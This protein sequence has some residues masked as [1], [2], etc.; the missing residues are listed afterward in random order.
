MSDKVVMVGKDFKTLIGAMTRFTGVGSF[1][2][3]D[4]VN[5]RVSDGQATA[6]M[7]GIVLSRATAFASGYCGLMALDGRLVESFANICSD[8]A[9]IIFYSDENSLVIRAGHREVIGASVVGHDHPVPD[10]TTMLVKLDVTKDIGRKI[11]YLSEVAY[12]D[13]SRPEVNC[14]ML[15]GNGRAMAANQKV[16]ASVEVSYSQ[17]V[18]IPLVLA[19][20]L[21]TGE[22]VYA[23]EKETVVTS[24]AAVYC[25]PAP[26][27]AQNGFPVALIERHDSAN[28]RVVAS[29]M[30]SGLGRIIQECESCLGRIAKTDAIARILIKEDRIEFSSEV[31]NA[32]FRGNIK[33]AG[34]AVGTVLAAPLAELMHIVPMIDGCSVTLSVGGNGEMFIAFPG[35]WVMMASYTES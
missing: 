24:G 13:N 6:S 14:V 12:G 22:S 5:I 28:R 8:V 32:K 25:M 7:F 35:G 1:G 29:C 31:G 4:L 18:A 27:Q 33:A 19:K 34:S 11:R 10:L 3:S 2:G 23:G 26:I 16:I 20:S 9:K 17:R 30:G 15:S 21:Q